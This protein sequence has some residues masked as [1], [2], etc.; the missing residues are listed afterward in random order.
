MGTLQQLGREHG[1]E[2]PRVGADDLEDA[3]EVVKLVGVQE[4]VHAAVLVHDELEEAAQGTGTCLV[5]AEEGIVLALGPQA[6]GD[7]HAGRGERC[8]RQDAEH[9]G[10][11]HRYE[12]AGVRLVQ[13]QQWRCEEQ[14][15]QQGGG[16]DQVV[17]VGHLAD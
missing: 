14:Q 6:H 1:H 2:A 10:E 5:V 17:V 9:A 15:D 4:D 8:Q 16:E 11:Q 13:A 12:E 3:S 7:S